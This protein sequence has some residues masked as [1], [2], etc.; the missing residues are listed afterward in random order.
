MLLRASSHIITPL[1]LRG[2]RKSEEGREI[3]H[4]GD[5]GEGEHKT[6]RRKV[7]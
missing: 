2:D 6:D 7:R 5:K 4:G 1:L 3:K